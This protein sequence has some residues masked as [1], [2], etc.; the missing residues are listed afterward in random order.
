MTW[1]H[2][3]PGALFGIHSA[4]GLLALQIEVPARGLM[5]G[6][7]SVLLASYLTALGLVPL[8]VG[9]IITGTLLGSAAVAAL[10]ARRSG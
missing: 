8:Q 5:D 7:V 9:A 3:V 6:A 2:A 1:E 4:W 10:S